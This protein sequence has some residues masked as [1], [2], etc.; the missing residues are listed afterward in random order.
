MAVDFVIR[1]A[2]LPGSPEIVDIAL[3]A[4]KIA[5]IAPGFVCEAPEYDACGRLACGG[6]IETHIHLD[7][8]GIIGRCSICSGT[9]AEAISETAKAKAAPHGARI[10]WKPKKR[11]TNHESTTPTKMPSRPPRLDNVIVS[12][13]NCRPTSCDS[14]TGNKLSAMLF[15]TS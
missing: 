9:L 13:R 7:K 2:R 4:G 6:L 3:E 8:A 12:T 5:A 10:V 1:N 14:S 11:F 15:A